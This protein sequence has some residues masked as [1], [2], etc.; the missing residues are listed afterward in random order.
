MLLLLPLPVTAQV[1]TVS[2]WLATVDSATQKIVLSWSPASDSTAAGYHICTGD[3]CRDYAI[4]TGHFDTSY[5]CTDHD[6][7][8][9]HRYRIHVIDSNHDAL[10]PL[11]PFFGNMV[12]QA[13]VPACA[14]SVTASWTPYEGMP[15]GVGAYRLMMC[16]EPFD[17]AFALYYSTDGSGPLTYSFEMAPG[18]THVSI[19]IEAVAPNGRLVS[20]S[21]IVSVERRT[22]D[23][24]T[25]FEILGTEY[26]SVNCN[27]RI[28]LNLDNTFSAAP[29]RLWRS[30]DASPW[31]ELVTL[32]G[33]P[34]Y[35]VDN[36]IN[37]YKD[38]YCY[39]LSVA[40][41]CGMNDRYTVATCLEIPDP[42]APAIAIPNT[43]VAG[44]DGPNGEFRPRVKGLKGNLYELAIY[45]RQGLQV[46]ATDDQTK[47]WRPD[48]SI[49][50]GA[51]TYALRIRFN[52]NKIQ[53]YTG[54][55][56]VIR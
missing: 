24:A 6:A 42:P 26:D 2:N 14:T 13:D 8:V 48:S 19:R 20:H 10:G 50:Q 27:V 46:F 49:P 11:T 5:I 35:Y 37:P 3:T 55:V 43:I 7:L 31:R 54:T 17:T 32:T 39:Q 18:A 52:N 33:A 44:D 51:Y 21:N 47:A 28:N 38:L 9:P 45:N 12:L 15:S 53:T 25:H 36:D 16:Q 34:S 4:V 29:Y 23:T 40:D 1:A 30:I 41:A 56:I 22:V